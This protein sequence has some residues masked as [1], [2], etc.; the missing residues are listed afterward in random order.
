VRQTW[1]WTI[2]GLLGSILLAVAAWLASPWGLG[3][4]GRVNSVA[5]VW[6]HSLPAL[7]GVAALFTGWFGLRHT[8]RRTLW[9]TFA[10]WS[11]PLL[12]CPPLLSKDVWAYLEQGWIVLQG[13]DPYLTPLSTLGGPFAER[14][15]IYWRYTTTVYP[16]LALQIQAVVVWLSGSDPF[17]S[18]MAMR[19]PGL[20]SVVGIGACLPRIARATGHDQGHALWLGLLNPLVLVHF[21]GGAHNDAW[22]V[23]LGV[24]GIWLAIRWRNAWP[25]GCVLVGLGM[26]IKQPIGLMMVAVAMIGVATGPLVPRQAWGKNLA[27]AAWRLPIGLLATV[28]GFMIPTLA[29]GWGIG[30]ATGSGAPQTA[31]SQS[32]AHTTAATVQWFT[33]WTLAEAMAI[34]GPIFLAVGVGIIAVL[35][36]R[37]GASRPVT[38]TAWGLVA[39]AFTYP[40]LQPWY[41]LWGGVLLGAVVLTGRAWRWVVTVTACLL[42]TSVLLDYG[43]VPIP[44]SQG[45]AIAAGAALLQV[46]RSARLA[47]QTT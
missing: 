6:A 9:R 41:A 36:W 22:A 33:G 4:A 28:T 13:F 39:F 12:A 43:N 19:L 46:L 27:E 45:I 37:H 16:P 23:A 26:A 44:A 2:V 3:F 40:S 10:L 24:A 29:G 25:L 1:G 7:L 31:G 8:N 30:W 14:V 35:G 21:I 5:V 17:W 20:A 18:M 15:D 42:I 38:F 34:V 47:V 32:V 11:L